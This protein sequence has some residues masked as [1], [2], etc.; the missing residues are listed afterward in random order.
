MG[1]MVAFIKKTLLADWQDINF[2]IGTNP[3]E[4]IEIKFDGKSLPDTSKGLHAYMNTMVHSN[5]EIMG[6]NLKR[7]VH[8]WG[9][10]EKGYIY[11]MLS[12][13]WV[14]LFVNDISNQYKEPALKT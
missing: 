6:Y 1:D 7:V 11:Y 4:N 13:P 10:K 5:Q 12:P 3:D 2:V 14:K 9:Y 8:Y